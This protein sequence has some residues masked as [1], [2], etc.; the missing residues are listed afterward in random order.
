MDCTAESAGSRRIK[1]GRAHSI[2][3]LLMMCS[4]LAV[5]QVTPAG[6]SGSET[7]PEQPKQPQPSQPVQPGAAPGAT[8]A[9]SIAVTESW[10][11]EYAGRSI[12]RMA[13]M[14]ARV[15]I[16]PS[17]E[18]LHMTLAMLRQARKYL[19][20]DAEIVRLEIETAAVAG[21]Q[22]AAIEATRELVRLDPKDTVAQL[23]LISAR[24]NE[25]QTAE[26]RLEMYDRLLGSSG[27]GLDPALRSRLAL[28]AAMLARERGDER[29]FATRLKQAMSLDSTNKEAAMLALGEYTA[30]VDDPVG[31]AQ[32][33]SNLML[34]DPLDPHLHRQFGQALARAGAYPQSRRFLKLAEQQYDLGAY[35]PDERF[36]IEMW[37]TKWAVE[38]GQALV[39]D[40]DK[41]LAAS[42]YQGELQNKR[43]E[44]DPAVSRVNVSDIRL[45]PVMERLR[46]IA[47]DS[48]GDSAALDVSRAELAGS[49]K[50]VMDS[51]NNLGDRPANDEFLEVKRALGVSIM[52]F[53][54]LRL[55]FNLDI[56]KVPANV[57]LALSYGLTEES[58]S[59]RATRAWQTL[60]AGKTEDALAQF[61]ALADAEFEVLKGRSISEI[62][63]AR[64]GIALSLEALGRNQEAAAI[65]QAVAA[66]RP[67]DAVGLWASARLERMGGSQ[68]ERERLGKRMAEIADAIPRYL[69]DMATSPKSF[70]DLSVTAA[71]SSLSGL[72]P[73]LLDIKIRNRARIPMG[74]GSDRPINASFLLQPALDIQSASMTMFATPEPITLARVFRLGPGESLDVRVWADPGYTGWLAQS[75]ASRA[76]RQRFRVIQGFTPSATGEM[77]AGPTC[78]TA[79]S[80][81]IVRSPL[82]EAMVP[83]ATLAEQIRTAPAVMVPVLA[84]AARAQFGVTVKLAPGQDTPILSTIPP[85][86]S[87]GECQLVSQALAERYPGLDVRGRITLLCTL[88]NAA[89]FSELHAFDEVARAEADPTVLPFAML[90]R[91]TDSTDPIFE[92][93]KSSPDATVAL[94]AQVHGKRLEGG[95]AESPVHTIATLGMYPAIDRSAGKQAGAIDNPGSELK[96]KRGGRRVG[97]GPTTP[98]KPR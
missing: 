6:L 9:T 80:D 35:R 16:P 71:N 92:R 96:E 51:V 26:A 86:I 97:E 88:P 75:G 72:D 98:N 10:L 48:I 15:R 77:I 20:N 68:P 43:A 47:A 46:T 66:D 85:G 70:L 78:L 87:A 82:H 18:E 24:I 37:V 8:S 42:R 79:G 52:E 31:R 95:T 2:V 44:S 1:F 21:D 59:I 76:V 90:T 22:A 69:D 58:P 32:L 74:M 11:N 67:L 19:P 27:D 5:G 28:D 55:W 50:L 60:R 30:R 14:D 39:S 3:A 7:P 56:D 23:R 41:R 94:V 34:A 29:L 33:L 57:D 36:D 61:N 17:S 81:G 89:T 62:E 63:P 13:L 53:Q 84:A 38:G 49:E 54:I 40:L 4:G 65:Y 91:A 45:S 25:M 12:V 64:I 73:V 93:A 83:A